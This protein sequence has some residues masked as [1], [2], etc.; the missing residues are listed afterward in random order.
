[1]LTT[2]QTPD[3][4]G[5]T[6]NRRLVLRIVGPVAGGAIGYLLSWLSICSGST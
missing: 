2:G 3:G 5:K 1:M 6:M 4:D